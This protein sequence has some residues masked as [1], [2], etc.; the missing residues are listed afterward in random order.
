M[1]DQQSCGTAVFWS[2]RHP[3]KLPHDPC[4]SMQHIFQREVRH[5][6]TVRGSHHVTS[7]GVDPIQYAIDRHTFPVRVEFRPLRYTVNVRTKL[8]MRQR[9]KLVP[10]PTFTFTAAFPYRKTPGASWSTGGRPG[11]SHGNTVFKILSG[12]KSRGDIALLP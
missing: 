12:W 4:L 3:L 8:F 7:I 5:V 1:W 2:E 9:L 10:G 6:T 11:G